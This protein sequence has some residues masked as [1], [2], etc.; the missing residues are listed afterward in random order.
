[1]TWSITAIGA[2]GVQAHEAAAIAAFIEAQAT[3]EHLAGKCHW[4]LG[5]GYLDS[6]TAQTHLARA[7]KQD[8]TEDVWSP[9][10]VEA[11]AREA[12][13]DPPSSVPLQDLAD[14]WSARKFLEACA[15]TGCGISVSH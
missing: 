15:A 4:G 1:M 10:R 8:I 2:T 13:W 3:V 6:R 7:I 9:G 11:M 14:Y 5:S 12:E